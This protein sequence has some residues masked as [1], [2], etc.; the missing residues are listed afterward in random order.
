[1]IHQILKSK[2][3]RLFLILGGFFIANAI[4]AEFMGVKIFSLERSLGADPVNWNILGLPFSFN[5]TTGVLLWPVVFIMTDIINEYYGHKGVRFLSYL[6][7][8]LITYGF[9]MLYGAIQLAPAD[10]WQRSR[11]GVG[12]P[13]MNN[14]FAAIFGQGLWIIFGSLTAF[15]IGQIADVLV[16]HRIKKMT[17]ERWIWMRA[18]GST[19]V[20]QLIDSYIVLFIAFYVGPRVN[21]GNGLPMSLQQVFSIGTGNYL[22]KFAMAIALTPV[23]YLVHAWIENYLG[24]DLAEKMRRSAMKDSQSEDGFDNIPTAG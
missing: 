14:A 16:F 17:G 20:S 24:R 21:P 13:D 15:L 8:S 7:A 19:L 23:I 11:A 22:Y 3:S 12:I 2:S 10:W 18:T 4:V 5:L 6:A 1:M 9:V